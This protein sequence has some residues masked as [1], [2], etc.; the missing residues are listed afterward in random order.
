MVAAIETDYYNILQE[1]VNDRLEREIGLAFMMLVVAIVSAVFFYKNKK[2][3][4][5][6]KKQK[7]GKTTKNAKNMP[8]ESSPWSKFF[9]ISILG[10]VVTIPS[11]VSFTVAAHNDLKNSQFIFVQ[12][13]YQRKNDPSSKTFSYDHHA[14][15]TTAE[16]RIS[17]DLPPSWTP[18]EFPE[19]KF[20]VLACYAKDTKL[21]LEIE[22]I[23]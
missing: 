8:K 18:E 5:N 13:E 22:I 4:T 3:T 17:V 20:K 15:L 14:T 12:A 23:D 9:A 10:L 7:S 21:L 6:Y 2:R 16:G 19:G 11:V 1:A